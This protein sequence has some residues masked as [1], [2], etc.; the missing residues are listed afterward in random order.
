M[1]IL[2]ILLPIV[3]NAGLFEEFYKFKANSSYNG[4]DFNKTIKYLNQIEKKNDTIY[5]KIANSYYRQK[6]YLKALIYYKK[7]KYLH[8][9]KYYN[10]ANCYFKL[11]LFSKAKD[12]YKASL[13]FKNDKDAIYNLN[14]TQ[15]LLRDK[16]DKKIDP[17][18]SLK[19]QGYCKL[20]E[21]SNPLFKDDNKTFYGTLAKFKTNKRFINNLAKEEGSS[22]AFYNKVKN[23]EDKKPQAVDKFNAL[24]ENK[25]DMKLK[26]KD[27]K[28]ILI[29]LEKR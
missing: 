12:F 29:L 8:F 28:T 26:N 22:D 14:L 5:L 3:L 18:S 6:Q 1:R 4:S 15:K 19:E 16:R 27:L 23:S 9:I 25:Y 24:I 2:I 7:I 10:M 13:K 21:G 17:K 20:F 11:S